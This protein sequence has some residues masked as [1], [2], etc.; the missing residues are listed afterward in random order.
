MIWHKIEEVGFPPP[1]VSVLLFAP[2]VGKKRAGRASF[3]VVDSKPGLYKVTYYH[4]SI[5]G[6]ASWG[7]RQKPTH[8]AYLTSPEK[9]Q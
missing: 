4:P 9:D 2:Y 1:W 7:M 3:Q 6:W 5:N 8:Y